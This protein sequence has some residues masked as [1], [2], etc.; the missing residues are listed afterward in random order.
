MGVP[1]RRQRLQGQKPVRMGFLDFSTL[2][3]RRAVCVEEVR[4][5]RE[6]APGLGMRVRAVVPL[7]DSYVLVDDR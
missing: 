2:E 3:R 7:S 5:N 6:L 4:V 1:R